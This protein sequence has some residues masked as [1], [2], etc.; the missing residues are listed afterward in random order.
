[1]PASDLEFYTTRELVDEL[2]RRQTFLGVVVQS[3]DDYRNHEWTGERIFNIHFN[4]N[5]DTEQVCRLL[6][7]VA[8]YIEKNHCS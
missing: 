8:G 4:S 7:T 1:M 2:M 3:H 5:L 6:Q